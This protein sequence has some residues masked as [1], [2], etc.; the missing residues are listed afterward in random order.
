MWRGFQPSTRSRT[1]TRALYAAVRTAGAHQQQA[2]ALEAADAHLAGGGAGSC[3][4]GSRAALTRSA[5]GFSGS[6]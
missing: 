2:L 6:E 1:V 3:A 4:V 5:G